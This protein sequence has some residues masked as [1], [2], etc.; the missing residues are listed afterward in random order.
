MLMSAL[1]TAL[2]LATSTPMWVKLPPAPLPPLAPPIIRNDEINGT[3]PVCGSA[4]TFG[5]G[6]RVMVRGREY[7]VDDS[8]CGEALV[9]NPDKYLDPDGTAKN[10]RKPDKPQ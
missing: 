1:G 2:S 10:A 7:L 8:A 5:K 9:A 4:L 6:I 3:C